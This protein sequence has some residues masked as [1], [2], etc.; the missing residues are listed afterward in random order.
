MMS[1]AF[2]FEVAE[3]QFRKESDIIGEEL[4]SKQKEK[5][6][7]EADSKT[8]T[9]RVDAINKEIKRIREEMQAQIDALATERSA[10]ED[11][12]F[13]V[14]RRLRE[15]SIEIA[16]I[17][18]RL[19]LALDRERQQEEYSKRRLEFDELS[20]GFCWHEK[21]KLHQIEGALALS[22][23]KRGILAD[24]MRLGKTLT[25]SAAADLL[26]SQKILIITP[27][28]VAKG[29]HGQWTTKWATHRNIVL[30]YKMTKGQRD[31]TF[32][33]LRRLSEFTVVLNYEAWRKDKALIEQLIEMR[34]DTVILDEAHNIKD[35]STS[36]YDG[37]ERIVFAENCC[38]KCSGAFTQYQVTRWETFYQCDNCGFDSRN[39]KWEFGDRCSVKNVFP[40]TGTPI[41]NKP[42]ELFPLLHLILPEVFREKND[43][44][45]M[46]CVRNNWTGK[47]EF[48]P[49]ALERLQSHLAGRY[50]A[51]DRKTAGVEIPDQEI[52]YHDIALTELVDDYPNQ[53]RIIQQ[54]SRHAQIILESTQK[55]MEMLAAIT[56]ILRKR[57]A[58]VWPAG[59]EIKDENGD[60]V[61]SVADDTKESI[62]IDKAQELV[63]EICQDGMDNGERAV[64]FSQFKGP[65]RELATRLNQQ[66]IPAI[67]FDGDTPEYIR[68]QIKL[69]FDGSRDNPNPKWQVV[70]ANYKTGGVGL[71]LSAANHVISL[72][73]EWNPGKNEQAY[74]RV[75]SFYKDS[76]TTVHILRIPGTI[77]SWMDDL[78]AEKA[79]LVSGVESMA[80]NLLEAMKNGDIV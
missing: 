28:D 48:R 7:I 64:V 25:V 14:R 16:N 3:Q 62:I 70:C 41:L 49:G 50:I 10:I 33:I 26:H 39:G 73:R 60:V 38:P 35:T 27:A 46:Y 1:F 63:A 44:L 47:W 15:L 56:I 67:V 71:E 43:F 76:K 57:Q 22:N 12:L 80:K 40:M 11:K 65:L 24:K 4:A 77:D 29:F 54:I 34:F 37:V 13:D 9:D 31:M 58:N 20:T 66:G 69:D 18:K 6:Q 5:A 79:G 23:V 52:Q 21:I 59:I 42:I 75:E 45:S 2:D 8:D 78:N 17:E 51:R 55:K 30:M 72:D 53:W 68:D 36:A 74:A 61:F 32:N 19:R